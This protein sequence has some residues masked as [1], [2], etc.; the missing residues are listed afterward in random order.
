MLCEKRFPFS[1]HLIALLGLIV[2]ISAC[3]SHIQVEPDET[4][5]LS[6][7]SVDFYV[8]PEGFRY[9]F[10]SAS[11]TTIISPH[12]VSGMLFG[13]AEAPLNAISAQLIVVRDFT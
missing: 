13:S 3:S 11:G 7:G 1:R 12:P 9:G 2:S 10:K 8:D 5:I 6:N 4:I